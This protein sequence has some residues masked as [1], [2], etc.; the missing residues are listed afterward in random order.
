MLGHHWKEHKK[1]LRLAI[2]IRSVTLDNID[3]IVRN[4]F[5]LFFISL[6]SVVEGLLRRFS[7]WWY[8]SF[9]GNQISAMLYEMDEK[10]A[11]R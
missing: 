1:L 5:G 2:Q 9:L 10:T 3:I 6:S 8:F 7:C 4:P 11:R